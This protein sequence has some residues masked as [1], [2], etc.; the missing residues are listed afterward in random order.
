MFIRELCNSRTFDIF[1]NYL[2][3]ISLGTKS[4]DSVHL[5]CP[6]MLHDKTC[7]AGQG[8]FYGDALVML[9]EQ[10]IV[11][12]YLSPL[13]SG[14]QLRKKETTDLLYGYDREVVFSAKSLSSPS[15]VATFLLCCLF[16]ILQQI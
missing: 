7:P 3:L 15:E 16:E 10:D 14:L 8:G 2:Q 5:V 9:Q 12:H 11:L 4:G 6:W 1:G 13:A